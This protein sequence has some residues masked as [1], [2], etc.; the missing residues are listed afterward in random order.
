M[1]LADFV[2]SD[3][4]DYEIHA[5]YLEPTDVSF[6]VF[7]SVQSIENCDESIVGDVQVEAWPHG[8]YTFMCSKNKTMGYEPTRLQSR[9][10]N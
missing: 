6:T 9:P 4:H 7:M 5:T 8:C 10:R 1:Q 3:H 2:S